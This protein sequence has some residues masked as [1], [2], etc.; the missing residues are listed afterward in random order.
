MLVWSSAANLVLS[1]PA[2]IKV[3][4]TDLDRTLAERLLNPAGPDSL[5]HRLFVFDRLSVVS[6]HF[7]VDGDESER[8]HE[9]LIAGLSI[10][11]IERTRESIASK[12]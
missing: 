5:R 11:V 7:M 10:S 3:L 8:A 2:M 6:R 1:E 4:I 9:D 12:S